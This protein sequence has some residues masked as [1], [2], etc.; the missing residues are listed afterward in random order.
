[1]NEEDFP[2]LVSVKPSFLQ[3]GFLLPQKPP[4]FFLPHFY[5]CI[6]LNSIATLFMKFLKHLY[7]FQ[8]KSWAKWL[9]TLLPLFSV[10]L[11]SKRSKILRTCPYQW[12]IHFWTREIKQPL[13]V[14]TTAQPKGLMQCW[15]FNFWR[16]HTFW[17]HSFP[18]ESICVP[19]S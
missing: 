16:L 12:W 10:S 14:I 15:P 17:N 7:S 13:Q 4:Y 11:V 3:T 8:L 6:T 1:M 18:S 9:P 19:L 2:V 5:S